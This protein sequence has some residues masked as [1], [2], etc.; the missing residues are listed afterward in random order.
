M[1]IFKNIF[2]FLLLL[3]VCE[4]IALGVVVWSFLE[5]SLASFELL[6]VGSDN[7]ARDTLGTLAKAAENSGLNGSYD[8]MNFIFS[9]LVKISDRDTDGYT[10]KEIFLTNEVGIVLAHSNSEYLRESLKK[11]KPVALYQDSLYTRAFRLRKWQI[12]IPVLLKKREGASSKS[13]FF[14]KFES[15]FPEINEPEIL[16]SAA[17]YHPVKLE[18]VA[19]IHMI[20]DRGNFRKFVFRQTELLEWL[21][22]ND[23]LI[24]LGAAVFLEC[25]YL[26]LT[27]GNSTKKSAPD[28][29][30]RPLVEKVS[31]T[32]ATHVPVLVKQSSPLDSI[33]FPGSLESPAENVEASFVQTTPVTTSE[34]ESATQTPVESAVQTEPI[35]SQIN[36]NIAAEEVLDAIYLG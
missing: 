4:S 5:S 26:L 14:S 29:N 20:Y 23:S 2:Y 6:K 35:I 30:S 7:R 15:F 32:N 31:H 34:T 8:D 13:I 33:V 21:F 16:L 27:L 36:P 12:G 24:A 9:R 25:I 10:I 28:K 3:I 11:R 18:R 19:A 17:V 1:R 22:K